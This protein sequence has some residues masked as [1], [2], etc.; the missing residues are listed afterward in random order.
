MP[1][2]LMGFALQS[3]PLE[4]SI[5]PS[6]GLITSLRQYLF[7]N[8]YCR[9]CNNWY[10]WT[11]PVRKP[12]WCSR[13]HLYKVLIHSRV[14]SHPT[15][16]LP[17]AGGRYSLGL[18]V[19]SREDHQLIPATRAILSCTWA[20]SNKG[21]PILKTTWYFRVLRINQSGLLQKKLSIPL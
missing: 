14:R 9:L 2:A 16:V 5:A 1:L 7:V 8:S 12:V 19:S 18:W 3:F 10:S 21:V 15:S 17:S 11:S 4:S 13:Y 20:I 6:S